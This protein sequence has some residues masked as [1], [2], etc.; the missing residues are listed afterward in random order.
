MFGTTF[1]KKK[2]TA[3]EPD[4][5]FID[6][7][8]LMSFD[9][10]H[11]EGR[12]ERP[13]STTAF[14]GLM[15][16]GALIALIFLGQTFNL[17]VVQHEHFATW[18]SENHLR[19]ATILADRGRI[20]DR[21]GVELATNT[22]VATTTASGVQFVERSYPLTDATAHMVGY[23]TYPKQDKN[24][25][26]YQDETIGVQGA[27]ALFNDQLSGEN[28]VQIA[29]T[30]AAGEVV[31]GSVVR[32][33]I[34]GRDVVLSIDADLQKATFDFVKERV[35]ASFVGGAA[36]IIDIKTG[37]LLSLVSYPSFDPEV[38]S[39]GIPAS[40][41]AEYVKDKRSPFV[42][43]A[44]SGLYAPGSIVKPMMA[45]A[46]L[47]ENIVTPEKTFVSTGKLVLPNPYDPKKPSIF[48]DWRVNGVVDMRR[49]I[50]VSS[51]VYFY[52]VGGGFENQKGLG[53]SNIDKYAARFGFGQ[54]TGFP[55][56]SEPT[57]TVPSPAWKSEHFDGDVWRVGDTYTTSIGQ[58]GWQVT[59]LQAIRA[60]AAIANGGTLLTPTILKDEVGPTQSVGIDDDKLQVAR[61][62]MRDAVT[63]GIAQTLSMP[64]FHVA[65]KTGTAEVGAEKELTNSLVIGFFPYE[66]PRYAFA[67]ILEHSKA[68][69]AV[70]ASAVMRNILEW[71]NQH[72]PQMALPTA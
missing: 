11:L 72:R 41:V 18:A 65:A 50:A 33:P 40:K 20:I 45:V 12:I 67:V 27:E 69:T 46:A 59:L 58:Y 17:D 8:N 16:A 28:G 68:G 55:D 37:E 54:H 21:N 30:N 3:L 56:D 39:S 26:W 57:G 49:A 5:I 25:N 13:L 7:Q 44:V 48:K 24:G 60:T 6:S 71:I 9:T 23:V 62:G 35:E 32:A 4:E 22:T 14:R 19:H 47:E 63:T 15:A 42:D 53:I 31:S 51:Y 70:G 34:Q 66:K 43:R 52:I 29:E 38:M 2:Y 61:E 10:A 64:T 36:A 1:R